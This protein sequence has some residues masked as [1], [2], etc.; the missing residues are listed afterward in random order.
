MFHDARR[1]LRSPHS[2][3]RDEPLDMSP[4]RIFSIIPTHAVFWQAEEVKTRPSLT[5]PAWTFW[6]WIVM[7]I[8]AFHVV[9]EDD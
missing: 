6:K 8:I 1:P 4:L 7:S 3:Y 2:S 9:R 5:M